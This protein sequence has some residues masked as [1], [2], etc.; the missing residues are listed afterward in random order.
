M[1]VDPLERHARLQHLLDEAGNGLLEVALVE[2]AV[3]RHHVPH[4]LQ[5]D[6]R[7]SGG[8][9]AAPSAATIPGEHLGH[10]A[11]RP[12][13][14]DRAEPEV[15]V[16]RAVDEDRVEAAGLLPDLAPEQRRHVDGAA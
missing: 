4:A 6:A 14:L 3:L 15:P 2:R 12:A 9:F 8:A 7:P 16:L 5:A 11:A 10:A 13:V 1:V